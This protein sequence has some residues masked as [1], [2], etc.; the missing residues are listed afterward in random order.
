MQPSR[1]IYDSAQHISALLTSSGNELILPSPP[2]RF[3]SWPGTKE[4]KK[5]ET[6]NLENVAFG[7]NVPSSQHYPRTPRAAWPASPFDAAASPDTRD[8]TKPDKI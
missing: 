8:E 3:S 5:M 2:Q 4:K 1:K 7:G 6:P